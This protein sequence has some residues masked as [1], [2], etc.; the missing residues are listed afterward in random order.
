MKVIIADIDQLLADTSHMAEEDIGCS[1]EFIEI[2]DILDE[3]EH[4]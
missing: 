2:D 3:T 1:L 4:W